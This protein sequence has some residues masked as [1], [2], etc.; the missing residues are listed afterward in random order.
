MYILGR[1]IKMSR[2]PLSKICSR[3]GKISHNKKDTQ[4][5]FYGK[6]TYNRGG[7]AYYF[8]NVCKECEKQEH[9]DK[10]KSG[11]YNY[12]KKSNIV[13]RPK[14]SAAKVK[15]IRSKIARGESLTLIAKEYNVHLTTISKIKHNINWKDV[16]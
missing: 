9:R 4:E 12:Y 7:P 14:L 6:W 3:C 1:K 5:K 10:Y 11:D 15:N 16:K 8:R 13:K 2:R